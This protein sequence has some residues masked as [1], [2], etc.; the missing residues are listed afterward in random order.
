MIAT[1]KTMLAEK[2][3]LTKWSLHGLNAG[4]T[5]LTLVPFMPASMDRWR[6]LL[7]WPSSLAMVAGSAG[8]MLSYGRAKQFA[9]STGVMPCISTRGC[10]KV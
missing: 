2:T 10:S 9:R 1:L 4:L 3:A 7:V 6:M 5:V 8:L